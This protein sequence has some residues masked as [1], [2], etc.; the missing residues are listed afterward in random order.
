[1]TSTVS[2]T[3]ETDP[4]VEAYYAGSGGTV[5][6]AGAAGAAEEGAADL[7]AH[8]RDLA[9]SNPHIDG[10]ARAV[11]DATGVHDAAW[12]T[13][14]AARPTVGL[15]I[16]AGAKRPRPRPRA[17]KPAPKPAVV[18]TARPIVGLGI[19]AGAKCPGAVARVRAFRDE[20]LDERD[21]DYAA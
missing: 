1:M 4:A 19:A 2:P 10:R 8:L 14:A 11:R 6:A 12:A 7:V 21:G 3:A 13:V 15:G 9:A 18:T 17:N 20:P 5:D 16:V